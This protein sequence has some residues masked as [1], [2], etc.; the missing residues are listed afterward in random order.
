M[1][2]KLFQ[3][4]NMKI[5]FKI[6]DKV[7][8]IKNHIWGLIPMTILRAIRD[9]YTCQHDNLGNGFFRAKDLEKSTDGRLMRIAKYNIF[10]RRLDKYR[11]RLFKK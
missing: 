1:I 2:I 4:I 6:G 10:Q 3:L 11:E 9:G 8:A 5:K 7:L